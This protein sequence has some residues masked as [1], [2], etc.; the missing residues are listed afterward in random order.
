MSEAPARQLLVFEFPPGAR[1]EGQLVGAL[2]RV[3]SG[4]TLL[5][6]DALFVGRDGDTGETVAVAM[7]GGTAGMVARLLTFRLE[8]RKRDETT[9]QALDGP[10]GPFIR[11]LADSLEPGSALLA[12]LIE[13]A[14]VDVLHSAIQRA[15]GTP[16]SS[17]FTEHERIADAWPA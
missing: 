2:E 4:G 12:V 5:I 6:R 15:Q 1:F 16:Q 17:N 3:E 7:S 8:P 13:H 10:S 9:R 14:W 11:S